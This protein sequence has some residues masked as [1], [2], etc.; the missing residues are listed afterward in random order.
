MP[1]PESI[2]DVALFL[3]FATACLWLFARTQR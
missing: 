3:M 1:S 2:G